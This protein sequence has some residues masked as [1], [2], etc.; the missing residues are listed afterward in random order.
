MTSRP[1][2]NL[3]AVKERTISES[4]Y[5]RLRAQA[6]DADKLRKQVQ[7]LQKRLS[8]LRATAAGVEAVMVELIPSL[9]DFE[10]AIRAA[11][12]T[13]GFEAVLEGVGIVQREVLRVLGTHGLAPL[14]VAA[15]DAFDFFLH[16]TP[17]DDGIPDEK[18]YV[19]EVLRTG[20]RRGERILRRAIVRLG[21]QP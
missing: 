10:R 6:D 14:E 9:D 20:Y 11:R 13:R 2:S 3:P 1:S 16:Q 4:E 17:E 7:E 15:G 19:L 8:A 12:E 5:Q 18:A 21:D